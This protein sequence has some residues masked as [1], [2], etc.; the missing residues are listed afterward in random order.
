[1]KMR[2]ENNNK[3]PITNNF[4]L[5]EQEITQVII[6]LTLLLLPNPPKKK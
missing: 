5:L 2:A 6:L 3:L 1:M 4:D